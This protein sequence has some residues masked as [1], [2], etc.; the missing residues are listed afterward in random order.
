MNINKPDL[1]GGLLFLAMTCASIF[2]M[3]PH[4]PG[5]DAANLRVNVQAFGA[6]CDDTTD[7]TSAI[8]AT[9]NSLT[10]GLVELPQTKCLTTATLT[11]PANV[12]IVGQGGSSG[13]DF[14]PVAASTA[15]RMGPA[16]AAALVYGMSLR[17]LTITMET[18]NST[19]VTIV[20]GAKGIYSNVRVAG[21]GTNMGLTCWKI[22]GSNISAF[23]NLFENTFA[24]HCHVGYWF[25]TTGSTQPTQQTFVGSS[26]TGDVVNG[27]ATGTAFLFDLES[28]EDST[29]VGGDIEGWATGISMP[30]EERNTKWY[31]TRFESNTA[32]VNIASSSSSGN[33]FVGSILR[34]A[35]TDAGNSLWIGSDNTKVPSIYQYVSST[36]TG[37][38]TGFSGVAPTGTIKYT[39]IGTAVTLD[40]PAI[41]GASNA[42]TFTITGAPAILYPGATKYTICRTVDNG[43]TITAAEMSVGT[44]GTLT[45]YKDVAGTAFTNSGTKQVQACSVSYTLQ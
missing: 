15:I 42:T 6:K 14:S 16:T 9:I 1:A 12:G 7:D 20:G 5:L 13:I 33:V 4:G 8:Q 22:D 34:S 31:G 40:I 11:V 18:A 26:A 32:D 38:A 30:V 25:T 29:F 28:A 41:S 39:V 3:L 45:L 23:F 35:V 37:T 2:T 27:D 19:G 36:Y 44:S 10:T 21:N 24:E 17:D 43:G